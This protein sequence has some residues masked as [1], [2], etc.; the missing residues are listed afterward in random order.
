VRS[1]CSAA[2]KSANPTSRLAKF[3]ISQ[4]EEPYVKISGHVAQANRHDLVSQ[5]DRSLAAKGRK[6]EDPIVV[7]QKVVEVY[8]PHPEILCL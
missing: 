3:K 7:K 2:L 1:F 8:S 5:R 4:L 6:I